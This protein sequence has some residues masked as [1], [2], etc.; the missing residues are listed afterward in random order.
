MLCEIHMDEDKLWVMEKM[1]NNSGG[2][3][4][5]VASL[6]D[7]AVRFAVTYFYQRVW[8]LVISV[9]THMQLLS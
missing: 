4:V 5:L 7:R 6:V 9:F 1:K 3:I 2:G 8:V